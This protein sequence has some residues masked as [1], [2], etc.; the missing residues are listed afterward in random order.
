MTTKLQSLSRWLQLDSSLSFALLARVWQVFSG[1]I[2]IFLLVRA[3]SLHEQGVFTG[4]LGIVGIQPLFELGMASVIVGRAA[5]LVG[6]GTTADNSGRATCQAELNWLATA[7][8]RWFT[9]VAVLYAIAGWA[10]GWQVLSGTGIV[11]IDWRL[12]VALAVGLAAATLAIAPRVYV[13]EGGGERE[14]IYRMRFWQAICGS[15]TMWMSLWFG[16]KLWAV[17]AVFT[18]GA[19]FQTWIAF[20]P[21]AAALL[22]QST[23]RPVQRTSNWFMKIGPVQWRIAAISAAHYLA[24]QMLYLYVLNYHNSEQAAPLGMTL[25]ITTAIQAVSLAWAQTKFP[26]ISHHQAAG[27]RELAGTL[28]RQTT[29]VSAGLLMLGMI[30]LAIAVW[31]LGWFEQGWE[32]RFVAPWL[33][34][35]LGLGY[36]A[37]HM[38]ALQTYYVLSRGA[39]PLVVASLAGLLCTAVAIWW[40]GKQYSVTG[41]VVAYTL[42]MTCITLPLHTWAYLRFRSQKF[43]VVNI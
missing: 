3:L 4:L 39:K 22:S 42:A 2:T 37:N 26:L 18:V 5:S 12:P 16:L 1:P 13:M 34:L 40:G 43:S 41:V 31:A 6:Q 14:F 38:L 27:Q 11:V 10:L 8:V 23:E 32:R 35:V 28:W 30:A 20:G 25:T 17:V 9:L 7:S 29:V 36:L 19:L 21:R 24:S 15:F 33:T